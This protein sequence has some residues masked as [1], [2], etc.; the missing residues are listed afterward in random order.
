MII[1]FDQ[2]YRRE[3]LYLL[4]NKCPLCFS[5]KGAKPIDNWYNDITYWRCSNNMCSYCLVTEI[6]SP[7]NK[8]ARIIEISFILNERMYYLYSNY[9]RIETE[10]SDSPNPLI[11]HTY[12]SYEKFDIPGNLLISDDYSNFEK[13]IN[14]LLILI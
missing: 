3:D 4:L 13:K 7:S 9:I 5:T 11:Y 12:T 2:T 14:N 8:E 6:I 10:V 1:D